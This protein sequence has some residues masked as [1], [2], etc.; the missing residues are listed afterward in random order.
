[1]FSQ[2]DFF[3][4]ADSTAS[5]LCDV[6]TWIHK[7]SNCNPSWA[8]SY[9]HI[10]VNSDD[11]GIVRE[12][13]GVGKHGNIVPTRTIESASTPIVAQMARKESTGRQKESNSKV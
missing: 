9:R 2:K 12:T 1:M 4:P 5:H 6:G 7:G 13:T 11:S 10:A 3:C 8:G